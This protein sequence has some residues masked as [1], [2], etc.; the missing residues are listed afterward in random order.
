MSLYI[1]KNT[2]ELVELISTSMMLTSRG[3]VR[4]GDTLIVCV[5]T[6]RED[7]DGDIIILN[8]ATLQQV[9]GSGDSMTPLLRARFCWGS[10]GTI[11]F[12]SGKTWTK[13]VLFHDR[14]T[15]GV[16]PIVST[17]IVMLHEEFF[18]KFVLLVQDPNAKK[19]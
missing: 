13:V 6:E 7:D 1:N 15:G 16:L 12:G 8:N 19:D 17:P 5:A 4:N 2:G 10:L 9:L 14:P 18:S 11:G 3:T